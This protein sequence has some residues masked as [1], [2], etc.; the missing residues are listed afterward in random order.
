MCVCSLLIIAAENN[1][2][3]QVS[4]QTSV[5][6]D[7]ETLIV[8]TY[9]DSH[10]AFSYSPASSWGTPDFVSSFSGSTGQ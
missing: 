9:Q 10:P 5:G 3:V 6:N 2:H 1:Q 7:D 8:N 4:W